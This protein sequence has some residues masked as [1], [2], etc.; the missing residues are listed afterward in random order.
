MTNINNPKTPL[1]KD[2]FE[3]TMTV[4]NK[5]DWLEIYCIVRLNG[6]KL[7]RILEKNQEL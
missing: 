4:I 1:R 7:L 3:V 2:F 5:R 6:K